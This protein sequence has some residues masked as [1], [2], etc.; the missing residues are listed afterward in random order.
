LEFARTTDERPLRTSNSAT[1]SENVS[2]RIS[3][4]RFDRARKAREFAYTR[5][6]R[7]MGSQEISSRPRRRSEVRPL[8]DAMQALVARLREAPSRR[9]LPTVTKTAATATST[10][11]A[12][13]D[14]RGGKLVSTLSARIGGGTVAGAPASF[15]L[16]AAIDSTRFCD[17][18]N[19][20]A[21]A[22]RNKSRASSDNAG[23]DRRS[24][25]K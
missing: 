9:S 12:K 11:V 1:V 18:G 21:R 7:E 8:L 4:Q 10:R 2:H 14:R 6:P 24:S 3:H 17:D 15:A 20:P 13:R 25:G 22:D 19:A 16:I 23:C 5:A